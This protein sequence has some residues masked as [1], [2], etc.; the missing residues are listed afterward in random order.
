MGSGW[1]KLVE[2]WLPLVV[3]A[4]KLQVQV[5][6]CISLKTINCVRIKSEWCRIQ[7][8]TLEI[9]LFMFYSWVR[10]IFLFCSFGI[11]TTW[12]C[13]WIGLNDKWITA[14]VLHFNINFWRQDFSCN[15][16]ENNSGRLFSFLHIILSSN[17]L[18]KLQHEHLPLS[19]NSI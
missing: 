10:Y 8:S 9:L 14:Y 3:F 2:K 4:G 19:G 12:N 17:W 7:T 11:M 5:F 1:L 18:V 16:A 6:K 15:L 13:F